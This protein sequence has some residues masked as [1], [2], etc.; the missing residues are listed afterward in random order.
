MRII[1][2]IFIALLLTGCFDSNPLI[3][4]WQATK[5]VAL[6]GTVEFTSDKVMYAGMF[7]EV[8]YEVRDNEVL[9]TDQMGMGSIYKIVDKNTMSIQV[10]FVGNIIYK[11]V[12]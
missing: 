1:I 2:W 10:P 11:R 5:K 6:I 12:E 3:G 7:E 4:K 8:K 9:V